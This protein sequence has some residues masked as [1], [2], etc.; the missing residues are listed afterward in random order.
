MIEASKACC[1][2]EGAK[3]WQ[4]REDTS[5]GAELQQPS[6]ERRFGSAGEIQGQAMGALGPEEI[7][8]GGWKGS[9]KGRMAG[10]QPVL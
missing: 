6:V 3:S 9:C 7:S 8:L 1:K 4:K 5:A 10:R 2:K